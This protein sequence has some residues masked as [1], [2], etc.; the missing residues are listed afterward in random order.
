MCRIP[1]TVDSS[2]AVLLIGSKIH[3]ALE[4]SPPLLPECTNEELPSHSLQLDHPS[5]TLNGSKTVE[6]N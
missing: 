1:S 3:S 6:V 5:L 2:T 4:D